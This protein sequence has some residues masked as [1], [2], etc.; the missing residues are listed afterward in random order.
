MGKVPV[1]R[2]REDGSLELIAEI[3]EESAKGFV[4]EDT[5]PD[6]IIIVHEEREEIPDIEERASRIQEFDIRE[7]MKELEQIEKRSRRTRRKKQ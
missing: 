1:Y 2:M 6:Y 7:V 4:G 5:V 3:N